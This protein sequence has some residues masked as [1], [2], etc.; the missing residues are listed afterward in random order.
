MDL[1]ERIA[2]ARQPEPVEC[3]EWSVTLSVRRISALERARYEVWCSR[4]AKMAGQD[5]G[6]RN[7]RRAARLVIVTAVT[8]TG[9]PAFA[10]ADLEAL[11]NTPDGA[12]V[13]RLWERAA[14]SPTSAPTT[15]APSSRP[16]RST[17]CAARASGQGRSRISCWS[18]GRQRRSPRTYGRP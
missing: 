5:E 18:S 4:D 8:E 7:A 9:K 1:R 14:T 16:S 2:G 12:T 10:D 11:V 15:T 17:C 13:V 6:E 3:P